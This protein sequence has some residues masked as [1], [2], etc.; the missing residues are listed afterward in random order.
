MHQYCKWAI[1]VLFQPTRVWMGVWRVHQWGDSLGYNQFSKQQASFRNV[2]TGKAKNFLE[3]GIG[4]INPWFIVLQCSNLCYM[5]LSYIDLIII[6]LRCIDL[7]CI[8]LWCANLSCIPIIYG[9]VICRTWGYRWCTD[10]CSVDP[11]YIELW[12][13]N[14][15]FIEV[16]F[17]DCYC[18]LTIVIRIWLWFN[19]N[20]LTTLTAFG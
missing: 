5:D 7:Q 19:Q 18:S 3:F 10:C 11:K 17:I 15:C 16:F 1:A 8:D 20:P 6:D 13:I 9:P 14:P 4:C 2:S 12:C